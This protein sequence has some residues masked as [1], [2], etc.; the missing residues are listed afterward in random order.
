MSA[1]RCIHNNSVKAQLTSIPEKYNWS[2]CKAYYKGQDFFG[3]TDFSFIL[4]SLHRNRESRIKELDDFMKKDN[5]DQ[6]MGNSRIDERA[7]DRDFAKVKDRSTQ[8]NDLPN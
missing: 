4:D 7:T 6:F 5:T 3:L 1:L 8:W 2:S